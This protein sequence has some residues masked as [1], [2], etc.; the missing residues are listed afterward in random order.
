MARARS[1]S[2]GYDSES[3]RTKALTRRRTIVGR[4]AVLGSA[5]RGRLAFF[6]RAG[7]S[8]G[9]SIASRGVGLPS[10]GAD[11]DGC[12]SLIRVKLGLV[13]DFYPAKSTR[14]RAS[15]FNWVGEVW[16]DSARVRSSSAVKLSSTQPTPFSPSAA[17]P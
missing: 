9:A 17:K 13:G 15:G 8:G 5:T 16:P 6:W 14:R 7:E 11:P 12:L 10:A 4:L 3:R 1:E 2:L